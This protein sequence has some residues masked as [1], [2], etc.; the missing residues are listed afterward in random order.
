MPGEPEAVA[1]YSSGGSTSGGRGEPIARHPS[2]PL[3]SSWTR[4]SPNRASILLTFSR[5]PRSDSACHIGA[6]FPS[7]SVSMTSDDTLADGTLEDGPEPSDPPDDELGEAVA[8]VD[9][10]STAIGEYEGE[11]GVA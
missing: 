6:R 3:R 7:H 1:S 8:V 9:P 5:F 4:S 10:P 2:R 11:A